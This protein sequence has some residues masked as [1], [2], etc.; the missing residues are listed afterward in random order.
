MQFP[1]GPESRTSRNEKR[2]TQAVIR[3]L[4][5]LHRRAIIVRT[6]SELL[7][8]GTNAGALESDRPSPT[9]RLAWRASVGSPA[10]FRTEAGKVHGPTCACRCDR[11]SLP[12]GMGDPTPMCGGLVRPPVAGRPV[13]PSHLSSRTDG[14]VIRGCLLGAHLPLAFVTTS[15]AGKRVSQRTDPVR[16]VTLVE[17]LAVVR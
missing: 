6:H 13:N 2:I 16:H 10:G 12:P 11:R 8:R 1:H 5:R 14:G 4:G 3:W 15:R 7:G 17:L 9:G